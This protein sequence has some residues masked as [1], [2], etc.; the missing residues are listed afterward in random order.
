MIILTMIKASCEKV[1]EIAKEQIEKT[2]EENNFKG[3]QKRM[4]KIMIGIVKISLIPVGVV[5]CM[6]AY[7]TGA[8][9]AK[10]AMVKSIIELVKRG[11]IIE[12]ISEEQVQ[13]LNELIDSGFE[14][15]D[16]KYNWVNMTFG[17]RKIAD[18]LHSYIVDK[19]IYK[20]FMR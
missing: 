5:I 18:E 13:V 12:E 14:E 20:F 6:T 16:K 15:M 7:I 11:Y 9:T 8:M 2:S 10:R 4:F 19:Y 1:N 17:W 3:S